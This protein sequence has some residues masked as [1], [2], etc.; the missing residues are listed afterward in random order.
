MCTAV[1][2]A[3]VLYIC[4]QGRAGQAVTPVAMLLL[5]ECRYVCLPLPSTLSEHATTTA[6]FFNL[7][8]EAEPFARP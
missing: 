2:H 7:F 5:R 6:V 4:R 1:L 8:S 3:V